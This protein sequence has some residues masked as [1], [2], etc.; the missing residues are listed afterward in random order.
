MCSK[1]RKIGLFLFFRTLQF[2]ANL[3][4]SS[5]PDLLGLLTEFISESNNLVKMEM[6]NQVQHDE[7]VKLKMFNQVQHD[8]RVCFLYF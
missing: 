5:F 4:E 1:P 3:I 6:L 2:C 7:A 8:E